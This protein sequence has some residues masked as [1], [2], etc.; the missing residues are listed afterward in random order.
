MSQVIVIAGPNGSGKTT[1]APTLLQ[2]TINI[3]DFV[4]AD[5]IA[6]GLSA[7]Q[8]EKVAIQAGRIML[9]RI[10]E[11]SSKKINFAFETTLAS[12][13]FASKIQELKKQGYQFHLIFLWLN[14]PQLAI[15]R[16]KERI[17]MG[18]HFV[19]EETIIRR[20]TS[21]L[22]NFF[23]LYKPLA[24]TWNLYDNSDSLSLIASGVNHEPLTI[25]NTKRWKYLQ[26]AYSV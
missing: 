9:K 19:P 26:E 24:D 1:S 16:V 21:G 20:Y 11:L 3:D 8:P 7:F 14:S 4:N 23:A 5:T 15:M 17:K 13:I 18:G 22:K 6:R 25:N 10:D 12:R 2:G